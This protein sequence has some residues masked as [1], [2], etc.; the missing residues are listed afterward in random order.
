MQQLDIMDGGSSSEDKDVDFNK[1]I[2]PGT[3]RNFS[4]TGGI[5]TVAL[6]SGTYLLETWGASGG[7]A[8]DSFNYD[9]GG[10]GGYSYGLY[11]FNS[12]TTVYIVVGGAG[13]KGTSS[14]TYAGGYNGGGSGNYYSG[15]GGGATHIALVT[16]LLNTLSSASNQLQ[17]L[18]VAGAGGGAQA[19]GG[20]QG[21]ATGG[22]GGGLTGKAG[23]TTSNWSYSAYTSSPG[24]QTSAGTNSTGYGNASFG[25]GGNYGSSYM[26]GGGA[27]WYGGAGGYH[28]GG[29][30]AG[31][32][33]Y[34][35]STLEFAKTI[36]GGQTFKSPT[37][38]TETGHIG[39]GYARIT[40][41][42]D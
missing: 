36:D 18:M 16:G 32:S 41:V 5:Q 21:Q 7:G 38:G 4:Y 11:T 30:G 3:E 1:I 19:T 40:Q 31:G 14:G 29:S 23:G 39:N 34:V 2:I 6:N 26:A 25:Q 8:N 15:G 35:K 20:T 42:I 17:V 33:G 9:Y 24:T 27:G 28:N 10:H 37:G 12:Q 13:T 22:A